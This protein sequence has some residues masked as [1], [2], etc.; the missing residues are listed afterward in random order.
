MNGKSFTEDDKKKFVEFLN[1]V[2]KNAKFND[3]TI[4]S[5]INFNKL[6]AHMQQII[7]TKINDHILEVKN[8]VE[9]PQEAAQEAPKKAAKA[10]K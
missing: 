3:L 8:V 4:E 2:A 9:A 6:L 7:L 1:T 10:K 5:I